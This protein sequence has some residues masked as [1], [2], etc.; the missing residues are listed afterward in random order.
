VE[1]NQDDMNSWQLRGVDLVAEFGEDL[2]TVQLK[3][4]ASD[5]GS[6]SLV[7]ALVD[8]FELLVDFG[9]SDALESPVAGLRFAFPGPRAN[10]IVGGTEISF[11]VPATMRAQL[12]L[13]DV[14]GRLVRTLLDDVVGPGA[15][16]WRHRGSRPPGRS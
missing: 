5:E 1:R 15:H 3:L 8:D 12:A 9:M 13:Y 16:N 6:G 7:E 14:G 10:P 2:G 11:Q 4:I